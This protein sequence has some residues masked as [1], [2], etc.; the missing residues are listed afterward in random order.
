MAMQDSIQKEF[1]RFAGREFPVQFE[2]EFVPEL[3]KKLPTYRVTNYDDPTFKEMV[4]TA[5]NQSLRMAFR[6]PNG[7]SFIYGDKT[8]GEVTAQLEQDAGGKWRVGNTFILKPP[9]E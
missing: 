6:L 4:A 8:G 3:N 9:G 5:D 7:A 1:A 2:E